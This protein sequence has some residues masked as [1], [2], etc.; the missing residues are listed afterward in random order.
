MVT[1]EDIGSSVSKILKLTMKPNK[2]DVLMYVTED[3]RG[4]STRP[5]GRAPCASHVVPLG[6]LPLL[7]PALRCV[8]FILRLQVGMDHQNPAAS[9][10]PFSRGVL[11]FF[12]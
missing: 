6:V 8:G 11:N 9:F 12:S 7:R 10:R 3:P 4:G 5:H 2:G 1:Y